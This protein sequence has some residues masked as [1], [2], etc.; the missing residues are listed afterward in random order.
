M[1]EEQYQEVLYVIQ[2]VA[3]KVLTAERNVTT[4][5][6]EELSDEIAVSVD[7]ALRQ[8]EPVHDWLG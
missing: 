1:G 3:K 5:Q 6:A 8:Q 7:K 2:Q 4:E